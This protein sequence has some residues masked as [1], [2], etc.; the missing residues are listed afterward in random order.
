MTHVGGGGGGGSVGFF[1]EDEILGKAYD[2]RLMRRLLGYLRSYRGLVIV[3]LAILLGLS[4]ADVAPPIIAKFI[5][6][7][8]IAPAVSGE[9][10]ASEGFARLGPLGLIYVAVLLA[11][12][13][14]RYA[15]SM[16]ASYVGQNAMYDLRVGLFRHLEGL[17]LSFFDRNPVGRLMTRITNDIDALTDMVTQGVVAIFGDVFVI[18]VIAI[19]LVILDWRLALVTLAAVPILIA[20]TMYFRRMMRE[21]FRAIRIRLARVN[22][23]LNEN[24]SGMAI[25][26]L[27]TREPRSFKDFDALNTDLLQANQGGIRAMALFIPSVNFTRAGTSAALFIAASYW[28]LGGQLTLGTLFAFW[29]LVERFFAPIQD[30][31]EKYNIM[32]AA[33]AS[34][35]RVFR[36]MDTEPTIVDPPHPRQLAHVRG[37]IRFENV[38]FAYNE[39]D[40]VLRDVSFTIAAGESVAIVGA[41]GAGKTSII[42]L[43][44][45]FYDVQKGRILLDG[46]DLREL[47]QMDVRRHVGVVL[48]DPFIFAGTIAS[49]IRLSN[50]AIT[51]AQ[52]RSAARFVNADPFIARLPQGYDTAVTERGSTLSV[53]Q[54][55]LLAFARAIAFN[56]EILLVLDEATSSV[57]TETEHLIQD[58]LAKLM[59][60]RTSIIIAHRLST[61]QN[62][63]RIIVLHKGRVVEMGTHRDL[64]AL[65]GVYHRLYELQYRAHK[66]ESPMKSA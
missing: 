16:L 43:I 31:S 15:Q 2:A 11:S 53:G 59:A 21:S 18:V 10:P 49:N 46:E 12:S 17:S 26:Q 20:M 1:Q 13:A 66:A 29:Q 44:S 56:P 34:S 55:Q 9:I 36:L 42:S 33:M 5:V 50:A 3:A 14:F 37:E 7:T 61:I 25:L 4:L 32:Q 65:R 39:G 35:E 51:D 64:L 47:R 6:D 28:I 57:D 23:Y 22:A 62:V 40:W 60:G 45:R 54:K 48:Q 8:A 30:L 52:V 24:I 63:D 27:F 41:T 19:V 38:S 58:A